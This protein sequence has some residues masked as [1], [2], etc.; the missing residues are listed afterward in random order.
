MG[1]AAIQ[2]KDLNIHRFSAKEYYLMGEAGVFGDE[3]KVELINGQIFDMSPITSRHAGVVKIIAALLAKKLGD[4]FIIGNQDPIRLSEFSEPEP[5]ISILKMRQDW[6][7]ESHPEPEDV[8]LL[9]EVADS[10]LSRD[11]GIKLPLYA[12]AGIPE[13][14]IVN[15]K[16]DQIEIFSQPEGGKYNQLSNFQKGEIIQHTII[17]EFNVDDILYPAK[18]G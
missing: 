2:E 16:E 3:Q 1:K 9:I 12:E 13:L 8:K 15:L 14:W 6:Y 10:S 11:R 7:T 17:G 18:K 4:N 5:D